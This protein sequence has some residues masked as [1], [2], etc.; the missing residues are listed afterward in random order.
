MVPKPHD[1]ALV[2]GDG[3]EVGAVGPHGGEGLVEGLSSCTR[4]TGY[5]AVVGR[6]C[7][8]RARRRAHFGQHGLD[9]RDTVG[10]LVTC[11]FR[12]ACGWCPS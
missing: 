8:V 4:V 7:A 10:E 12:T 11:P 2:A 5:G 3:G 1:G 9:G 6:A